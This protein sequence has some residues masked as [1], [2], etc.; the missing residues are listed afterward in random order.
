MNFFKKTALLSLIAALSAMF[1]FFIFS[2]NTNR[3]GQIKRN[4]IQ[5]A[6]KM[7]NLV[8]REATIHN[9]EG[10]MLPD[11]IDDSIISGVKKALR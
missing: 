3:Y 2:K 11:E 8:Y 4:A 1:L 7:K 9:P 10:D 6:K 5:Y